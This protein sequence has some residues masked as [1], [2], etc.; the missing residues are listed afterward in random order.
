MRDIEGIVQDQ[1]QY[2]Q[3]WR[4]CVL[5]HRL[6]LAQQLVMGEVV[7]TPGAS[8]SLEGDLCPFQRKSDHLIN[9]SPTY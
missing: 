8:P 5:D 3:L 1:A 2:G 4:P 6:K 9:I 7:Y